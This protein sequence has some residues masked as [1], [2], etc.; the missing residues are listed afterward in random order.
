[1]AGPSGAS[2]LGDRPV[3]LMRGHGNVV[4]GPTVQR[5][6]ARAIY[7]EVNA[8]LLI[9]AITLGGPLIY[10][11]AEEGKAGEGNRDRNEAGH[12]TDRIWQLWVEEAMGPAETKR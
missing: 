1:M 9:Q 11:D 8:K 6:V 5:V 2:P 4:V 12:A 3:A 10:V 7:T